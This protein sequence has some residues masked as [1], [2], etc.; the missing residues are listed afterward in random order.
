MFLN[1]ARRLRREQTDAERKLWARLRARQ[2]SG[3]KFRRQHQIGRYITDFCC[4]EHRLVVELDGGHHAHQ[5]QS[6]Q[7]RT[8]FLVQLGYQVL[9]GTTKCWLILMRS[10]RALPTC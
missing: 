7:R 6:D 10:Y 4:P 5:T 2:V 1:R 8:D 3:V 9:P